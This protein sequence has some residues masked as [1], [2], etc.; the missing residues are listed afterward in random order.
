MGSCAWSNGP[1]SRLR[2][3]GALAARPTRTHNPGSPVMQLAGR[4]RFSGLVCQPSEGC[5]SLLEFGW[6]DGCF[7]SETGLKLETGG[8]KTNCV[9]SEMRPLRTPLRSQRLQ[10]RRR[11][12]PFDTMPPPPPF[13]ALGIRAGPFRHIQP[14]ERAGRAAL[15]E[16]AASTHFGRAEPRGMSPWP[17]AFRGNR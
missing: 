7:R 2:A 13:A 14:A 11:G 10:V 17:A 16:R 8:W 12:A 6:M 5:G 1:Q 4:L 15:D 9:A 3:L